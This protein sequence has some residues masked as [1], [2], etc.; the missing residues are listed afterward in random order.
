MESKIIHE[1]EIRRA[2]RAISDKQI[3]DEIIQR[4]LTA[5]TFAPSCFNNQPWR[6]VVVNNEEQLAHVKANLLDANY[7]AMKS[8]VIILVSTNLE[9]DCRLNDKRDYALFDVGIAVENLILQTTRERLIAHPIAGFKPLPIKEYF[10][11]PSEYILIT[12]IVLGY[13]GDESHLNEKHRALEH[14]E[15]NRKL[16]EEVVMYNFWIKEERG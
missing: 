9:L 4:V 5:A 3:P 11:I 16:L 6:F 14:S 2:K 8:P 13:P 10:G 12:L 7:W 15:R 1:I